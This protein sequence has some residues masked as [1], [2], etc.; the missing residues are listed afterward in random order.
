MQLECGQWGDDFK[1]GIDIGDGIDTSSFIIPSRF[2]QIPVENAVKHG[3]RAI[4][5][6]KLL[7]IRIRKESDGITVSIVNNGTGYQPR[8]GTS[9]T[10]KGLQVIYQTILLLNNKNTSKIRF[11]IGKNEPDNKDNEGTKVQYFFPS[12]FDDSCFSK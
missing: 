9:G 5:G 12:G 10:G 3:L 1:Y 8:L 11:E 2:I 6:K 4:E 7:E